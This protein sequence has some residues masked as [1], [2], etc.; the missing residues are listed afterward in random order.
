MKK[1]NQSTLD[2]H[3]QNNAK[4]TNMNYSNAQN[5]PDNKMQAILSHEGLGMV[6]LIL[7]G[8][9]IRNFPLLEISF[10]GGPG[11]LPCYLAIVL[12]A[13]EKIALPAEGP[14]TFPAPRGKGQDLNA[15][16]ATSLNGKHGLLENVRIRDANGDEFNVAMTA[17]FVDKPVDAGVF[18]EF[19]VY[20]GDNWPKVSGEWEPAH[21]RTDEIDQAANPSTT[22]IQ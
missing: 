7:Q 3:N 19:L 9:S 21:R 10:G 20:W 12:D 15:V 14:I 2:T 13:P 4:A 17:R 16:G 8:S 5:T 1:H 6:T 22:N 11:I 18:P